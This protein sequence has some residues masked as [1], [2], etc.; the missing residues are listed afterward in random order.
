M[1]MIT[2][3]DL[4]QVAHNELREGGTPPPARHRRGLPPSYRA[5][6]T[7]EQARLDVAASG[8]W[9]GRFERIFIDVRVLNPFASSNRAASLAATASY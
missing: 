7:E 1:S 8:V 9:G 4:R 6:V 3:R 2:A 5:A